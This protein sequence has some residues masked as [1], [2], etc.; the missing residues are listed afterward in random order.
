MMLWHA[1]VL[2]QTKH[3][4]CSQIICQSLQM[5]HHKV[6]SHIVLH[7]QGVPASTGSQHWTKRESHKERVKHV[8]ALSSTM[9]YTQC[10]PASIT[11]QTGLTNIGLIL[12]PDNPSN[13]LKHTPCPAVPVVAPWPSAWRHYT[14]A[15]KRHEGVACP[16]G[17]AG[18]PAAAFS[19]VTRP[20][21][22]ISCCP[23]AAG[24]M[25]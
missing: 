12:G 15:G 6:T 23:C 14:W 5:L 13:I 24:T 19:G 16:A 11:T 25:L 9:Q 22:S 7:R 3:E 17:P 21:T 20:M 8:Q 4:V 1:S 10:L 18:P 2:S